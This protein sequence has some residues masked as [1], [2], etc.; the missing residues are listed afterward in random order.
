MEYD[1]AVFDGWTNAFAIAN[2][3]RDYLHF[4]GLRRLVEPASAA[5]SVVM[6]KRTDLRAGIY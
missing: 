5:E 6:N 1:G 3:A 4:I 2:I